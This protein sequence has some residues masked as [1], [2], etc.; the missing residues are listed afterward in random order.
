M[1][2]AANLRGVKV[3]LFLPDIAINTTPDNY[4]TLAEGYLIRFEGDKWA[5]FGDLIRGY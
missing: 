1:R 3:P 2:Q 5:I 4:R